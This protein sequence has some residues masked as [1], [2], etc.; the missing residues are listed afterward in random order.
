M[1]TVAD[2]VQSLEGRATNERHGNKAGFPH[3]EPWLYWPFAATGLDANSR[4][5]FLI[6]LVSHPTSSGEAALSGNAFSAR[7]A[8]FTLAFERPL[9][10]GP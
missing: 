2:L 3:F 10:P 7:S 1:V 6:A 5:V 8:F 4:Y 9:P